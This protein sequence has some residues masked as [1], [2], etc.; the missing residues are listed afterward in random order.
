VSTAF[1]RLREVFLDDRE[2]QQA[3]FCTYGL[4]AEFFEGEVL[5]A[6]F[7]E[8]LQLDRLAGSAAGYLNAADRTLQSVPV[9]VFYDHLLGDGNQLQYVADK[10]PVS[11][12]FHPKLMLLDY[13]D[14]LR[15]VVSS[16][17]LTR[18]AWTQLLELFLVEDLVP[19]EPHPWADGLR[20]F[21]LRLASELPIERR[22]E[23]EQLAARLPPGAAVDTRGAVFSSWDGLLLPLAL[24][25]F[26][27]PSHVDVVTPFLEGADGDGVFDRFEAFR[28]TGRLFLNASEAGGRYLVRGPESKIDALMGTGRWT[29]MR[30]HEQW[31]DDDPDAT[32]RTLH[33]KAIVLVAGRQSRMVVGSANAT[34]AALLMEP[35]AGNVELVVIRDGVID[36]ARKILPQASVVARGD[37]DIQAPSDPSGEDD[38][39]DDGAERWVD[40]ALYWSSRGEMELRLVDGA[41][42]LTVSYDG[43][44]VGLATA[45][46]TALPLQVRGPLCIEVSDGERI[47]TVPLIVADPAVFIPRGTP[48]DIDLETFC[49]FLAGAREIEAPPGDLPAEIVHAAGA[50]AQALGWSG[51]IPWRRLLAAVHGLGS[52][53][54]REA[55]FPRGVEFVLKNETRL[56]GLRRRLREAHNAGRLLDADYAYALH[57]VLRMLG[58]A[59]DVMADRPEARAQVEIA[60]EHVDTDLA[61][62]TK[63]FKGAVA[64]QMR[65]LRRERAA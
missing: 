32:L 10:V 55:P 21:V 51:A 42:P 3:L 48:V 19:H 11:G 9:T 43:S 60:S 4:S 13:G 50:A 27:Q 25:G 52:E 31:K 57:E 35:P 65:L 12:A 46:V 18:A 28:P 15:A 30:V 8:R 62:V 45:P 38:M 16:A 54:E 5:P 61:Q 14:R 53:L 44:E 36:E 64:R 47:G 20:R 37:I 2:P 39:F 49:L 33:G 58:V 24:D 29:L 17:N 63:A 22:A 56:G 6:L 26:P 23:V 1:S 40:S 7:P 59:R 41:P 34:R